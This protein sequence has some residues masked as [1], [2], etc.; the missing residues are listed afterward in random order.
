MSN[1]KTFSDIANKKHLLVLLALK[2]VQGLPSDV[3][4]III[5]LHAPMILTFQIMSAEGGMRCIRLTKNWFVVRWHTNPTVAIGDS[6]IFVGHYST[7]LKCKHTFEECVLS[8]R[9]LLAIWN[10]MNRPKWTTLEAS[11]KE[12]QRIADAFR[13]LDDWW[14]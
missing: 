14:H 4:R 3:I 2:S 10:Y 8:E 5:R 11:M 9:L 13:F 12:A 6:S 7:I 1:I